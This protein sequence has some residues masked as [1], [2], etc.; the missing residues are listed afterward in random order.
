MTDGEDGGGGIGTLNESSLHAGIKEFLALPGDRFEVP[1]GGFV[2]DIV[3][4]TAEGKELIE[5]Q[6]GSFGALGNK[7][8]ALLGE[9]RIRIVH[10]IAEQLWIAKP[11]R[12]GR[13]SPRRGSILEMFGELTSLPTMLDHPNL[14]LEVLLIEEEQLR[15]VERRRL[16]PQ[17][18]DRR[19]RAVRRSRRFEGIGDLVELLPIALAEPWTTAEL[20][21][22]AA[23]SRRT[24]QAMAYCL[25]LSE[26]IVEVGR[27]A[28]GR[29]YRL[30]PEYR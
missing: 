4:E 11:G 21:Q 7:L 28:E 1:L 6:T 16:R 10:P 12:R 17:V 5:I 3:R 13:R 25:R 14:T 2:I 29:A 19:L 23:V 22:A 26:A 18:L 9:H 27:G 8:D 20:A 15:A 24:A 30:A